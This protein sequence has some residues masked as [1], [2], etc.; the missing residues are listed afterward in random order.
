MTNIA[1]INIVN[2]WDKLANAD[3]GYMVSPVAAEIRNFFSAMFSGDCGDG[4]YTTAEVR[5]DSKIAGILRGFQINTGY[6]YL[7]G[8][9]IM[10]SLD[11][12][13]VTMDSF[14]LKELDD[15]LMTRSTAYSGD[16]FTWL[17]RWQKLL[18]AESK[19]A[20]SCKRK[21]A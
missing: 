2:R 10:F 21:T 15:Y 18:V 9:K 3:L 8:L 14:M 4:T 17:Y 16:T 7:D 1:M 12:H 20:R 11:L 19:P 13:S 6:D 5:S